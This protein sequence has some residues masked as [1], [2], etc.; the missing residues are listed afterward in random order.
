VDASDGS[1]V[2]RTNI[3]FIAR[4]HINLGDS[5]GPLR[6]CG[7]S[8]H[9]SY[10]RHGENVRGIQVH[11]PS[12]DEP[13]DRSIVNT[14]TNFQNPDREMLPT[15]NPKHDAGKCKRA[16]Y[17]HF[18]LHLVLVAMRCISMSLT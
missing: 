13:F 11:V 4:P 5:T 17:A 15:P 7:R 14:V 8:N 16:C 10:V 1:L 2:P 12:R 6:V 18:K 3:N 9:Y